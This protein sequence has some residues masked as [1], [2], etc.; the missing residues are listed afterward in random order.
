LDIVSDKRGMPRGVPWPALRSARG[1][2]RRRSRR[3]G[4]ATAG[5]VTRLT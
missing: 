3:S 1:S 2:C 5:C 4:T